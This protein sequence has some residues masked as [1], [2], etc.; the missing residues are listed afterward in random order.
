MEE[1]FQEL[2]RAG[3]PSFVEWKEDI[4]RYE[5]EAIP[6]GRFGSMN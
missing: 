1:A 3:I 6:F 2:R 4:M 5:S